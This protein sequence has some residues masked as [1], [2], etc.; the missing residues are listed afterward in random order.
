MVV[1]AQDAQGAEV[2]RP[3]VEK[4]GGTYRALLDQHNFIG[5]AYNLK[6]VPVG[7]AVDEAGQLVMPVS[8]VDIEDAGFRA[9]LEQWARGA[10]VPARWAGMEG[11][12]APR[13]LTPDGRR[14]TPVF[15]WLSRYWRRT[16][17]QRRLPCSS[18][19]CASTRR[20]G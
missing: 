3:W 13:A 10:V 8:S 15:S 9:E 17:S 16:K 14:P 4:A 19:R 11:G 20:T 6:Y 1:I 5:K 18:R 12:G 2:T 7:I